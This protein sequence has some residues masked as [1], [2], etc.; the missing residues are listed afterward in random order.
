MIDYNDIFE[1]L[2][3]EKY[4]ETLQP[5]PKKFLDEFSQYIKQTSDPSPT[6]DD[7]NLFADSIAKARKQKENAVA[8]FKELILRRK[9]KIL[10]LVFVATETGIMKRDYENMLQFEKDV[11]DRMVKAFEDGDKELSN[12]I[13]RN[14]NNKKSTSELTLILA[15]ENIEE[16]IDHTGKTI[17]PYNSGELINISSDIAE[18]LIKSKKAKRIDDE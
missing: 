12:L 13:H 11:F 6:K 3:T 4:S 14:N 10:N 2:R 16:F 9:K 17:G 1:L 8:L 5:L 7:T 15:T 18:I